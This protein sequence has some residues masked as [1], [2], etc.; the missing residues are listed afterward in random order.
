M[1]TD[2]RQQLTFLKNL[3]ARNDPTIATQEFCDSCMST[4]IYAAYSIYKQQNPNDNV[5]LD[6][7]KSQRGYDI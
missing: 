2:I 3:K 7:W 1:S 4:L 6:E 5:S